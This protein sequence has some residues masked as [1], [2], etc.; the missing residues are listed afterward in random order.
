MKKLA[1]VIILILFVS[2]CNREDSPL[3][4]DLAVNYFPLQVGNKWTFR[5]SIDS[6]LLIY[7]ITDTIDLNEH[8]YFEQ[9]RTFS[10]G[11]KDTNYFRFADD[12]IVLILNDG[13][14][15]VYIDFGKPVEEEWNLYDDFFGYIK[16]KNISAQVEAGNFINIIEVIIDNRSVSD[17]LELNLYAPEVGL[18]KSTQFRLSL[19][20]ASARVNGINYP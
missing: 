14:D 9:V 13:T 12:N 19:T 16:Q 17:A 3:M 2:S 18:I 20:L 10:D 15:Y 6:S 11:T 1:I 4:P 5:S 8:I 7:E